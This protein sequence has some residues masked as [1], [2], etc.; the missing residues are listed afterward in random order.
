MNTT[1]PPIQEKLPQSAAV[2][3][4]I[5][6]LRDELNFDAAAQFAELTMDIAQGIQICIEMASASNL[7]RE[8]NNDAIAGDEQLPIVD[9]ASTECLM[10]FA[11]AAAGMLAARAS[12]KIEWMNQSVA[13]EAK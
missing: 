5:S 2:H 12:Q 6:F 7:A 9:P 13:K 3:K 11:A 10:R 8:M 4:P 1:Q